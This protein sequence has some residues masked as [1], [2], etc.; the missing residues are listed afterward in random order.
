MKTFFSGDS[1]EC[2]VRVQTLNELKSKQRDH[3]DQVKLQQQEQRQYN[4]YTSGYSN[5]YEDFS[6]PKVSRWAKYLDNDDNSSSSSS[7]NETNT[8]NYS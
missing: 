4:N 5:S 6:K 1:K 8:E 3:T 7:D 2:R